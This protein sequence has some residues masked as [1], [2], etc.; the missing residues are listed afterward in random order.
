[1]ARVRAPCPDCGDIEMASTDV[2]ARVCVDDK[3]GSYAFRCPGCA[4]ATAKPAEH[5]VI[6]LLVGAGSALTSGGG[7]RS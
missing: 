6:Q 2:K 1:M 5:R 3:A 7:R 4:R